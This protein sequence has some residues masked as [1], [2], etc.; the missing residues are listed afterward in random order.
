MQRTTIVASAETLQQLRRVAVERHVSLATIIR[1]ALDEK[2]LN[3]RPRPRSAGIGDSGH[4]D[5]SERMSHER[6][7]PR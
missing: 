5:T 4:T 6:P 2:A 3:N 7:V 1:E